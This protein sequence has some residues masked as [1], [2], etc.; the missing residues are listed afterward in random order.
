MIFNLILMSW[1]KVLWNLFVILKLFCPIQLDSIAG[2]WRAMPPMPSP[3][4]LF[5][6]GES[7]HLLFAIA[8][9]DLQTN[10]SLDSVMCYDSEY[11]CSTA[12]SA[13]YTWVGY[14]LRCVFS[15]IFH[16]IAERWNGARPR[17]FLCIFTAM[18][19][20]HITTW[21]TALEERQMTS[22]SVCV[23]EISGA[24]EHMV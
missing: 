18:Q 1:T 8:G 10:E 3:R 20:S 22:K 23:N 12:D 13:L 5:S 11:V 16:F 4:C 2:D 9:K 14:W 21:C 24:Q 17:N 19:L 6:L 15:I 7:E